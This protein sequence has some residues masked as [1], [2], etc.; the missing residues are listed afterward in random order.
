MVRP[1][2][3]GAAKHKRKHKSSVARDKEDDASTLA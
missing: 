3:A 1:G 2:F